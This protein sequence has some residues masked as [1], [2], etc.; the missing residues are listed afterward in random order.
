MSTAIPL[1]GSSMLR[2][3]GVHKG[4][5]FVALGVIVTLLVMIFPLPRLVLDLFL[6]F[7]L[8]FSLMV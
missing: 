5:L 4:E 8:T 3:F 1:T 7:N 6:S 2:S